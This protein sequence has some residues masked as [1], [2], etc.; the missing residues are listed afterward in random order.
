M[1]DKILNLLLKLPPYISFLLLKNY[2]EIREADNHELNV[3]QQNQNHFYN[4]QLMHYKNLFST[5]FILYPQVRNY[6]PDNKITFIK[7]LNF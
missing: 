3:F 2:K 6:T 4:Q 7:G 5:F 1:L